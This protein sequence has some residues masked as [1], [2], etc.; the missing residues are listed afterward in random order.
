MSIRKS[1]TKRTIIE[2]EDMSRIL[3]A[4]KEITQR[5]LSLGRCHGQSFFCYPVLMTAYHTGMRIGE[6]FA[7]RWWNIDLDKRIIH[8]RENITEAKDEHGRMRLIR[9]TPKTA[10]SIRDIDISNTLRDVLNEIRPYASPDTGIVFTTKTGNHI[11][12]SNFGDVWRKLLRN[13]DMK[14]KYTLHEFRHT[15]TTILMAQGINPAS[16]SKRLGHASTQT[17]LNVY[18]HAVNADGRRMADVFNTHMTDK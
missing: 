16:I 10:N 14:G 1:D 11:S 17:T 13:L 9:Y 2:K 3:T 6:I 4:A 8:V 15:H 12:P 18:S 5:E 7:L